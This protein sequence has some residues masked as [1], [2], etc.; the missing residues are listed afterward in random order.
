[1]LRHWQKTAELGW[2]NLVELY[3]YITRGPHKRT[4]L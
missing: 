2:Q 1:M 3:G 4:L